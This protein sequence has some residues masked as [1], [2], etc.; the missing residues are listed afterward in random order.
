MIVAGLAQQSPQYMRTSSWLACISI[1]PEDH[2]K[3]VKQY[4]E[5][6]SKEKPYIS[7]IH[8]DFKVNEDD[9]PIVRHHFGIS[10]GKNGLIEELKAMKDAGVNHIGL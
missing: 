5:V 3:R 7:F 4:R 6:A 10:T 8:L 1:I 9:A 2:K